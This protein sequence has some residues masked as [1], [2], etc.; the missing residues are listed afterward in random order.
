VKF[1]KFFFSCLV[2]WICISF[3]CNSTLSLAFLNTCSFMF[4]L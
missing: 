2:N 4:C 1:S 3:S